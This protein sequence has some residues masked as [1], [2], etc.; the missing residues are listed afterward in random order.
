MSEYTKY[1]D[2]LSYEEQVDEYKKIIDQ[3]KNPQTNSDKRLVADAYE[4]INMIHVLLSLRKDNDEYSKLLNLEDEGIKR[5]FS[6]NANGYGINLLKFKQ[7]NRKYN[8]K[9]LNKLQNRLERRGGINSGTQKKSIFNLFRKR[10][11]FNR[12]QFNNLRK[13]LKNRSKANL[14]YTPRNKLES[15]IDLYKSLVQGRN[16]LE[17]GDIENIQQQLSLDR[18]LDNRKRELIRQILMSKILDLE[19]AKKVD[20]IFNSESNKDNE[21]IAI[22]KKK[23]QELESDMHIEIKSDLSLEEQ[24]KEI[25]DRSNETEEMLKGIWS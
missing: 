20:E 12:S 7:N 1:M 3:N 21:K 2:S 22:L 5:M 8:A 16:R 10:S 15:N 24:A 17:P 14:T 18:M 9:M 19:L 4:Q 25:T 13:T 23:M 6:K 11:Q